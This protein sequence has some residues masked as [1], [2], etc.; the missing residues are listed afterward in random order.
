MFSTGGDDDDDDDD[1]AYQQPARYH[2]GS[3]DLSGDEIS[4]RDALRTIR[5]ALPSTLRVSIPAAR[6]ND[7]SFH[8]MVRSSIPRDRRY[9]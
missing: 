5:S 9:A 6:T 3:D 7:R 2:E 8:C 1:D 4:E